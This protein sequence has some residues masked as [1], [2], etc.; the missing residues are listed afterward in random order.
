MRFGSPWPPEKRLYI[1]ALGNL[2]R[3]G[4]GAVPSPPPDP[5]VPFREAWNGRRKQPIS[6]RLDGWVIELTKMMAQQHEMPYQGILRIWI[7]E[8]LRR[9]VIEGADEKESPGE[10]DATFRD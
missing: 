6:L 1:E 2:I 8:G 10:E 9:A 4:G 7:E 5:L 3:G